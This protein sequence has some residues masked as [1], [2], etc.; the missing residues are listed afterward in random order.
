MNNPMPG[1]TRNPAEISQP[2]LVTDIELPLC[3]KKSPFPRHGR[4]MELLG[5]TKMIT[6]MEHFCEE[7]LR[8][9]GMFSL[10]KGSLGGT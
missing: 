2:G 3:E 9:F 6:G 7:K 5:S 1:D 8:E 4:D 10:E